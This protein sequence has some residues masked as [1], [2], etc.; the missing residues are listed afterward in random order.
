[1]H[2]D[3]LIIGTGAGGGTLAQALAG[4]GKSIGII[5]RGG[6]LPR[7]SR[8]WDPAA[9]NGAGC[10]QAHETWFDR[11][12][13]PFKPY[14]HY[15]VGGNTKVYGAA[16]L[17]MRQDDFEDTRHYGGRSPAWP[18][19]YQDFEP[20]YT[21]AEELYSVHGQRGVDALDPPGSKPYPHPALPHEPRMQELFDDLRAIG[22]RPSPCPLGVRLPHDRIGD[23]AR[24]GP[25]ARSPYHLGH[26]DG[27]PDPTE[28]KADA[29]VVGINAALAHRNVT[30]LTDCVAQRLI[31][32]SRGRAVTGVMVR[33]GSP[34]PRPT[35]DEEHLITADMVVVA[36]GAINSA[37]LL[38]RSATDQHPRGLANSSGLVGRH[39][40]CH[41]NGLVIAYTPDAPNPST[42]GKTFGL[43]DFYRG[44]PDSPLPLGLIQL[45]GRMDVD[46]IA[47]LA[48]KQMA[49]VPARTIADHCLDFFITAED[50]PDPANRVELRDDGSI[51]LVYVE[52]NLE[53]FSRLE[54]KL[55]QLVTAVERRRG[56][57][58]PRFLTA[59]LGISGTSHQCG[60]LRF[61][62][63]PDSSVLDLNCRAHD[64]DNLY[65]VDSS[66]FPS[67]SAVNPSLTIMANA[68]RV[69]EH[70]R[71]RLLVSRSPAVVAAAPGR[72]N[73][74]NGSPC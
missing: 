8:N 59:K 37:A 11:H 6:F 4:T 51:R 61:G 26:F 47:G 57:A 45:M 23:I 3:L 31:T 32:D 16:L 36:C 12:D 65:V 62:T 24:G 49:D 68:L 18:L 55:K 48:A 17:R 73:C 58:L 41:N 20:F 25:A 63:S 70:L 2:F 15:W 7:E 40:M 5:E 53:A 22:Q 46:S 71:E 9:V 74:Q 64:L 30:L 56:R 67:S 44:A 72:V 35:G 29:H 43:G 50:L 27:Y 52:N 14:T 39:Y 19:R 33:M 28:V 60:T 1:M 34:E 69:A 42:F 38:L 21:M 66:F 54:N 10:Y 13:Q